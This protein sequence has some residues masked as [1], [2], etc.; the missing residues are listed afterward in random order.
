MDAGEGEKNGLKTVANGAGLSFNVFGGLRSRGLR[1]K[2]QGDFFPARTL[3]F[4]I[5]QYNL[6]VGKHAS[7]SL[8]FVSSFLNYVCDTFG[9]DNLQLNFAFFLGF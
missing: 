1:S 9:L 4:S 7:V 2:K 8:H 6:C 3:I 5:L